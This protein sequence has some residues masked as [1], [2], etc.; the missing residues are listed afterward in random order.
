MKL[1]RG[2]G[3]TVLL[4]VFARCLNIACKDLDHVPVQMRAHD[5]TQAID[6]MSVGRHRISRKDPSSFAHFVRDV[7]F[8]VTLDRLI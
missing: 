7:E 8:V 2:R 1:R 3:T 5:D 4:E 6:L